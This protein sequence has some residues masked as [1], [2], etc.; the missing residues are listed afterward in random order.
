MRDA[1]IAKMRAGGVPF[2]TIA[3]RLGMSLGACR[4]RT[5]VRGS[6]PTPP[7]VSSPQWLPWWTTS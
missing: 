6:S 2:R 1:E 4:M 7:P 3:E 5:A